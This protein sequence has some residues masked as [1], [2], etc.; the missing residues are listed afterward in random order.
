MKHQEVYQR[1]VGTTYMS[2]ESFWHFAASDS[3]NLSQEEF[4]ELKEMMRRLADY[5]EG[6]ANRVSGYSP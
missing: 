3:P 5:C 4:D 2:G 1:V 6:P